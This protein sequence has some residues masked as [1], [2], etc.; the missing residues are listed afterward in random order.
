MLLTLQ[1]WRL[2]RRRTST[3]QRQKR[4]QRRRQRFEL[5]VVAAQLEPLENRVL[6]TASFQGLGF[7]PAAVSANG[8]V[9]VGNSE[10]EIGESSYEVPIEWTAATGIT[11]LPEPGAS[12]VATGVSADGSVIVGYGSVTVQYAG[13]SLQQEVDLVWQGGNLPLALPYTPLFANEPPGVGVSAPAV[14]ANG[15]VVVGSDEMQ[16]NG[17]SQGFEWSQTG[18]LVGLDGSYAGFYP[19]NAANAVSADGSVVVGSAPVYTPTSSSPAMWTNSVT[20]VILSSMGGQAFGVSGNG[21][22]VVGYGVSGFLWTPA[23]GGAVNLGGVG[24]VPVG[25]SNDGSIIV[26]SEDSGSN[27]VQALVWLGSTTP[28]SLQ[29]VL[30][31]QY[32][33]AAAL[34]GWTLTAATA[35]TPDGN[36]IVGYSQGNG[37][38]WIVQLNAPTTLSPVLN[39]PLAVSVN[40]NSSVTF[41]G[42]NSISVSDT[43]GSGN[44]N[45][46]LTLGVT[47]GTLTLVPTSGSEVDG[48]GTPSLTISGTL[49]EVNADLL[50]L[51]YV[52]NQSSPIS[53]TLTVT[54]VDTTDQEQGSAAQVSITPDIVVDSVSTVD[55]RE[56]TVTYEINTPS[57]DAPFAIDLARSTTAPSGTNST[58]G[59]LPIASFEIDDL[60]PGTY[61]KTVDLTDPLVP[62][63]QLPYVLA[64]ADPQGTLPSDIS[65]DESAAY[66]RIYIIGAVAQGFGPDSPWVES[67]ASDLLAAGYT[68]AIPFHWRSV[69]LKPG[70]TQQAGD[71]LYQEILADADCINLNTNDVIDVQLIGHSRGAAVIAEAMQDVVNEGTPSQPSTNGSFPAQLSRGYYEM[72]FLDPHPASAGTISDASFLTPAEVAQLGLVKGALYNDLL[73]GYKVGSSTYNDPPIDIPARVNQVQDFWQQTPIADLTPAAIAAFPYEQMANFWG[74]SPD[75]MTFLGGATIVTGEDLTSLGLGHSNVPEWYIANVIPTIGYTSCLN[76]SSVSDAAGGNGAPSGTDQLGVILADNVVGSDGD[77]DSA[78][79][80]PLTVYAF[81]LNAQGSID[82]T[83]NGS[84]TLSMG[85][86]PGGGSLNGTLAVDAVNGV[87]VFSDVSVDNPGNG[88][89]FE[90][91]SDGLTAG[92]SVVPVDFDADQLVVTTPPPGSIVAGST[93]GLVVSAVDGGDNVDTS[94]DGNVSITLNN[95]G[96]SAVSLG[97]VSA[98]DSMATFSGLRVNQMGD[99]SLELSG[100]GVAGT[101]I[102]L[103]VT[104]GTGTQLVVTIQ[105]TSTATAGTPFSIGL[106]AEDAYGN[107]DPTF[108][109]SVTLALAANP[110]SDSLGGIVTVNAVAGVIDFSDLELN[111]VATGYTI[112]ATADGLAAVTSDPFAVT[113]VA[114]DQAPAVAAPVSASVNEGASLSFSLSDGNILSVA[115][116]DSQGNSE[117]VTLAASNGTVTLASTTG[118]VFSAG[119]NGSTSM[120]VTG[121]LTNLNAALNGMIFVPTAGFSG[122]AALAISINDLGNTGT[123][124][125][126]SNSTTV[127]ITVN[128]LPALI[129]PTAATVNENS[130][131]TLSGGNAISVTDTAGSGNDNETLTLSV[132]HGTLSLGSQA[133]LTVSGAGTVASPMVVSGILSALNAELSTLVYTP[134]SGYSGS[135]TL[136]VSILDVTDEAQG[137]AAQ[138]NITVNPV[139]ELMAPNSVSVNE[140]GS[141]TFLSSNGNTISVG[142]FGA[143]SSPDSLTLSVSHGTLTLG[144]TTGLTYTSGKNNS[145]SLSVTGTVAN[146]NAALNGLT[147]KPTAAFWG[148]DSLSIAVADSGDS[149]SASTSVALTINALAP[150]TIT[151]PAAASAPENV[152]IVF[153]TANGNAISVADA[154]DVTGDIL[155]LSVSNGTLTLGSTPGLTFKSTA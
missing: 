70:Q 101:S 13:Y 154:N 84:V 76:P 32:G 55:S 8:D 136:S 91:T 132:S 64:A 62:D 122:P 11:A 22:F 66:F 72:T 139:L 25:V 69:L 113:S 63:P 42:S 129:A 34:N 96:G 7:K 49:S 79:D 54:V 145:A 138:L 94:F 75:D 117:Q 47:D 95:D 153:S 151:A 116:F 104:P 36:T 105:P 99:Y 44:N 130:S 100:S 61:T 85:S 97:S 3:M 109:G 80:S 86:D 133:E 46:Q 28:Q 48:S 120:T 131:L 118:L 87:A 77:L 125:P 155:T 67:M 89:T 141:L 2:R 65:I 51:A 124:G 111:N 20:P 38:G 6:L 17:L 128:P 83:F 24:A 147:Y 29:T 71:T 56:L 107:V 98:V 148:S 39:I 43:A 18:G 137:A 50:N 149:E 23:S 35:I 73:Q 9:V 150:P 106:S 40:N 119:S 135:D 10:V 59:N 143:G 134:T 15:D 60:S 82:T 90:A 92:T 12:A 142:D 57:L 127:A 27:D 110:G 5:L 37:E 53:D 93:F 78:T 26:G 58:D 144:S 115:D 52:P 33:L 146:L 140:D 16:H 123:G 68:D 103:E 30:A 41:S 21:S 152:S 108:N 121:T 19:Y 112:Q 114:A 74:I 102:P 45:E 88:Y 81:A 31:D 4:R 126:L 1:D 14:S